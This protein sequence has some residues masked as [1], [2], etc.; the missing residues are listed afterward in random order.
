MLVT[1]QKHQEYRITLNEHIIN[2]AGLVQFVQV[3]NKTQE[4]CKNI[5]KES[6]EPQ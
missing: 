1:P 2:I 5:V 3:S 4:T 6:I